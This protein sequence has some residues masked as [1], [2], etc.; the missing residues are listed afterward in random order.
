[1]GGIGRG[2]VGGVGRGC[3]RGRDMVPDLTKSC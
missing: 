1:M 3:G 2:D